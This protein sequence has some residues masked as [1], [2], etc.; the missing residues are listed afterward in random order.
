M[1][2]I[3]LFIEGTG[4]S[5]NGFTT[6]DLRQKPRVETPLQPKA[7]RF[8]ITWLPGINLRLLLNPNHGF[9]L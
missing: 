9:E 4:N 2:S 5:K 3:L 6:K 1:R 8:N 7:K